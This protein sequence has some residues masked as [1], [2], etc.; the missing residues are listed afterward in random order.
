MINV[1]RLYNLEDKFKRYSGWSGADGVFSFYY[2]DQFVWYFSDTFIGESNQQDQRLSFELINNSLAISNLTLEE[3]K[4][5]Y[6]TN[7]LASVFIPKEGYFWLQDG[8][9]EEDKLMI[10][11]LRMKNDIFSNEIFK[12]CGISLLE[13]NLNF[14]EGISYHEHEILNSSDDFVIGT[15]ILKEDYYYLFN[16]KNENGNKKLFLARTKSLL[17]NKFEYLKNDGTW[18]YSKDNL[19]I[20]KEHFAAEFTVFKTKDFYYI[21]YTKESLGKDIYLLKIENLFK[22]YNQEIL[23]YSCPEH[24]GNIIT[25]NSKIQKGLSNQEELIISYNVNSLVNEDH[26]NLDIYRPRFLKV[27]VED[28]E[29]EFKKNK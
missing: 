21:A 5:I 15:A 22:P 10:Y 25:Y 9:I 18:D 16:Y 26:K 2:N 11:A 23:L 7:P 17:D 12:I 27:K 6:K 24:Q 13:V 14:K 28:I 20:L 4:F 19:M 1:E 3:F 29:N 8:F